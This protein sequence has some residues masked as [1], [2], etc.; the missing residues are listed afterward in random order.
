MQ[1]N[2]VEV[3][4]LGASGDGLTTRVVCEV[5]CEYKEALLPILVTPVSPS[6]LV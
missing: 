2:V 6:L 5:V 3:L 1:V 4:R